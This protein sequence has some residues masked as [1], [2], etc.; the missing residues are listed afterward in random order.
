M[1]LVAGIALASIPVMLWANDS[2]YYANTKPAALEN[3]GAGSKAFYPILSDW[4]FDPASVGPNGIYPLFA[5]IFF[6]L[7]LLLF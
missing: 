1:N 7:G 3:I 4:G 5:I 2:V 6:L